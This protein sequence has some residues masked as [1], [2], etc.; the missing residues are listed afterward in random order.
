[1]HMASKLL[2]GAV[3]LGGLA[4]GFS[5][6]AAASG[7]HAPVHRPAAA[8]VRRLYDT[9]VALNGQE[10]HLQAL[11]EFS[12]A[13]LVA[14]PA[15]TAAAASSSPYDASRAAPSAAARAPVAVPPAAMVAPAQPETP[16]TIEPQPTTGE[17][18]TTNT[19]EPST[20]TTS[21]PARGAE[22]GSGDG[23]SGPGD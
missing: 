16:T 2:I 4:G 5:L 15:D 14:R 6:A 7:S 11:L 9:E 19:S 22:D 3:T 10:Q 18:P 21:V 17:P 20:T 1:M 13:E 23:R 12:R 8:E